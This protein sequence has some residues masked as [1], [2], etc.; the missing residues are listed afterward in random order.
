M[1]K[2][3]RTLKVSPGNIDSTGLAKVVKTMTT[4]QVMMVRLFWIAKTTECVGPNESVELL[5]PPEPV[6]MILISLRV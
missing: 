4:G 5:E 2:F 3:F 6:K 1:C